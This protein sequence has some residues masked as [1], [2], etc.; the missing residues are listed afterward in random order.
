MSFLHHF[1]RVIWA[2]FLGW[3]YDIIYS[4]KLLNKNQKSK[5]EEHKKLWK[6][7]STLSELVDFVKGIY[8]YKYDGPKGYIDH[9]NFEKEWLTEFGDCDDMA[10][11]TCKKIKEIYSKELECCNVYGF[12]DLSAKPKFWH[13]DC[14]YKFK[15][16]NGYVLFNYGRLNKLKD[17]SELGDKM[18]LIYGKSYAINKMKVWKCR[19]M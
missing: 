12:A 1:I 2:N 14:V 3:I 16:S 11:W 9:N 18:T 8:I 17:L 10:V 6:S 13:Y 7:I 5:Y 15:G 4:F 19:W